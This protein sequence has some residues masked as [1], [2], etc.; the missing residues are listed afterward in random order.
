VRHFLGFDA[1]V[2][3]R[4]VSDRYEADP[5]RYPAHH[6]FYA[7]LEAVCE[8]IGTFETG[9]GLR[10]STVR[11]Y[12]PTRAGAERLLR[13]RGPLSP[14]FAGGYSEVYNT[15]HFVA[16]CRSLMEAAFE[17]KDYAVAD[18]YATTLVSTGRGDVRLDG[19]NALFRIQLLEG[20][21]AEAEG[22]LREFLQSRPDDAFALACLARI[23]QDRGELATARGLY[24][25]AIALDR[26]G[27]LAWAR[28]RL[29]ML[30]G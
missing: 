13:E 15:P 6:R 8:R 29:A 24:E 19:L 1:I 20:R 5:S 22:S 7:D 25:R 9:P 26:E 12:R 17:A 30:G 28:E 14:A 27:Q 16:F 23:H 21:I 2:T 11:V 10:G 4:S 18:L 3:N